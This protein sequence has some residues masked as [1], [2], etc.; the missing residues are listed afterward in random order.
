MRQLVFKDESEREVRGYFQR[1]A[2]K[3]HLRKIADWFIRR[4]DLPRAFQLSWYLNSHLPTPVVKRARFWIWFIPLFFNVVMFSMVFWSPPAEIGI[5]LAAKLLLLAFLCILAVIL[6]SDV[7]L[8][9]MLGGTAIGYLFLLPG[10]DIWEFAVRANATLQIWTLVALVLLASLSYLYVG[11]VWK[12]VRKAWESFFRTLLIFIIGL[13]QSITIGF[14]MSGLLA[15]PLARWQGWSEQLVMVGEWCGISFG[16]FP[17][18][19][20]FQIPV[21]L[22]VGIVSQILW[23]DKPITEPL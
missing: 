14:I 3:L 9:R 2:G 16:F 8:P 20:L 19:L 10:K 21:A 12:V 17:A 6:F 23:E 4:Y 11:E 7:L 13:S 5:A 15:P 22:F 1:P 18:A